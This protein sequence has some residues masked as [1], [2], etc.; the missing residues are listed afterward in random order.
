VINFP[1][2]TNTCIKSARIVF[3]HPHL[4]LKLSRKEEIPEFAHDTSH[5]PLSRAL[6]RG[7]NHLKHKAWLFDKKINIYLQMMGKV[8]SERKSCDGYTE[9][10]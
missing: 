10:N 1:A 6:I 2:I 3:E 4:K 8:I 7:A 5:T 9:K